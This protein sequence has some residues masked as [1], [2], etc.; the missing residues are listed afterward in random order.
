[1]LSYRIAD[2]LKVREATD[3]VDRRYL[4]ACNRCRTINYYSVT[5]H[6][7]FTSTFCG[8][9]SEKNEHAMTGVYEMTNYDKIAKLINVDQVEVTRGLA[10]TWIKLTL[11]TEYITDTIDAIDS[12]SLADLKG[13]TSRIVTK[14]NAMAFMLRSKT[15]ARQTYA[16]KSGGNPN[17][18][19]RMDLPE[20]AGQMTLPQGVADAYVKAGILS[21]EEARVLIGGVYELKPSPPPPPV[22]EDTPRSMSRFEAIVEELQLGEKET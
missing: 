4:Y 15:G 6:G 21:Q 13:D 10:G 2:L 8:R 17:Y 18:G 3:R 5:N 22:V 1:V 12:G 11:G 19:T 9:C 14:L 7:P 20:A 16:E